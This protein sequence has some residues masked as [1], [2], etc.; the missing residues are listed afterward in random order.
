MYR[1][2]LVVALA[3]LMVAS[4]ADPQQPLPQSEPT[5]A[6]TS[7]E[8]EEM[9]REIAQMRL[10]IGQMQRNLAQVSSGQT[11]L[12]HQFELDIQMWQLLVNRLEKQLGPDERQP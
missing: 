3:M 2:L 6:R 11:A 4:S 1:S 12:K 7:S 5:P 9:R 10:L 8:R